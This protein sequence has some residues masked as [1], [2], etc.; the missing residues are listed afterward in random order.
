MIGD[1]AADRDHAC[2]RE[3]QSGNGIQQH[4]GAL[5]VRFEAKVEI[6]ARAALQVRF[7]PLLS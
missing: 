3:R 1:D 5:N 7:Q 4:G 6:A 2:N